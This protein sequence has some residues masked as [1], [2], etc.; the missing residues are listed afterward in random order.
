M[1]WSF[2]FVVAVVLSA[3]VAPS[4]VLAAPPSNDNFANAMPISA[5][6][7]AHTVDI[8][9]ATIEAA[10]PSCT[11]PFSQSVWYSFVPAASGTYRADLS[12]SARTDGYLMVW[13][14]D[15]QGFSGLAYVGCA[16]FF[17]SPVA[18][19]AEV[20]RTY[21]LQAHAWTGDPGSLQVNLDLVPPPPNDR[22][23]TAARV[24]AV[25]FSDVADTTAATR[26]ASEPIGCTFSE[27]TVWYAYTPASTGSVSASASAFFS[28]TAVGVYQGNSL[29]SLTSLGCN[30]VV[31]LRLNS[32]TTYYFQVGAYSSFGG[33]IQF[34]LEVPPPPN[35]AL[36][37]SPVDPSSFTTIQFYNRSSDPA[38]AEL[39]AVWSFGDGV[40]A[41]D[42]FPTHRYA[43]DGDYQVKLT[44][45]TT[46]GRTAWSQRTVK[47]ATHEVAITK[48]S[49]PQSARVGQTRQVSV[50]ITNTR[51]PERVQ[52]QLFKSNTSGG[53]DLV[54]TLTQS[55][56]VASGGQTTPF[57]F[58]YTFTGDDASA[59]K[60]T[61]MAVATLMNSTDALPA[62]NQA[63][64]L[65]TSVK[66]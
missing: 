10:E 35:A 42:P 16:G 57:T 65:S 31:T 15:G 55:V 6:P 19:S 40:T 64:S 50:G 52:V 11:A 39:S 37:F 49:T 8:T 21:Y 36:D 54:G 20:G 44:V 34:N 18:F 61:F 46:D 41:T 2:V 7:F 22:F 47:V 25:P 56:S 14:Q 33:P 5:V 4:V 58:N 23:A 43:K 26:E 32:G 17:A 63:V 66:R 27:R 53:F 3:A 1:R 13:R 45:T 60:V 12:G 51:Y 59:S 24:S 30:Q 29:G 48:F 28:A 38:A 62:D 9:D